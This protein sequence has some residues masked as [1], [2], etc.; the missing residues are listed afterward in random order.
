MAHFESLTS[1]SHLHT[2]AEV[3]SKPSPV[4]SASGVYA[5]FFKEIP[6]IVPTDGCVTKDGLTLLY[7][8]ISPKNESSSQN[9]RKRIK[10]HYQGNAEGSTLRLTLGVL[11]A[12]K[13][14]FPLRRVGSG[15]RMTLTHIGEQW[16]DTWMQ[17]NALVCWMEHPDPYAMEKEILQALSL[18]LNLQDNQAHPFWAELSD[19][20]KEAKRSARE[21]PIADETGQQRS[22]N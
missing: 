9:I 21:E 4:P 16:L 3:L 7:V 1:P 11:L 12:G 18:P 15:K 8:G 2:R 20:R 17:E 5:W 22:G 10:S 13:S 14:G 19:L 6:E